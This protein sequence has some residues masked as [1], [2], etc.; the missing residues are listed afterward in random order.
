MRKRKKLAAK[1]EKI[2]REIKA[3]TPNIIFTANNLIVTLRNRN[4]LA[5][6]LEMYPDGKYVMR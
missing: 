2:I 6:W 3:R 5:K 1:K 4:Q